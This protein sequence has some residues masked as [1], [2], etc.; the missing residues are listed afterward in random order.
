MWV[1]LEWE[2]FTN[3]PPDISPSSR[4]SCNFGIPE[5]ISLLGLASLTTTMKGPGNGWTTVPFF[6]GDL[7]ATMAWEGK[8]R[9]E[10]CTPN[11]GCSDSGIEKHHLR[12]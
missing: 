11:Q 12:K 5:M 4:N 2:A 7:P 8:G 10:T 9:E 6:S 1:D 3:L